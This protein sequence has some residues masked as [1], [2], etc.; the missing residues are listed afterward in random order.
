MTEVSFYHLEHTNLELA[1]PKL[2][3]K[4]L[5]LGERALVLGGTD[6]RIE[7]LASTLWTYNPGSWLPH[8]TA[9]DGSAL[10]QPI[11][12]TVDD[13]NPNGATF[14]FLIE[15]VTSENLSNFKRCIELFDGNQ[16]AMVEMARKHWSLYKEAGHDLLYWQQNASGGWQKIM[17]H[18]GK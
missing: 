1:L 12:L 2:L 11:W 14:L 10:D 7:T 16:P 9:K 17:K 5:A 8:G 15:G 3:E 18:N 4:T 6:V 13:I